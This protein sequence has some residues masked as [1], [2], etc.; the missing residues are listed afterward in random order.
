M[1]K[2]LFKGCGTAI[3]TPFK[4]GKINIDEFKKAIEPLYETNELGFS[5]GLKDRLFTQLAN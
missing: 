1:K 2:T 3:A 4:D 5:E